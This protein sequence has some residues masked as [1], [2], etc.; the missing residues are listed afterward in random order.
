M[1]KELRSLSQQHEHINAKPTTQK[2]SGA[3]VVGEFF[4]RYTL[5]TINYIIL[6]LLAICILLPLLWILMTSLKTNVEI[7]AG[8]FVFPK[9]LQWGNYARAWAFTNMTRLFINT[10]IVAGGSM[11]ILVVLAVPLAY[12]LSRFKFKFSKVIAVIFMLGLFVNINYLAMPLYL[13]MFKVSKALG[14]RNLLVNN[15]IIVMVIYGVANLPFA[16]YLLG[17]Y[18]MGLS[19]GFE[20][21]AKIDGCGYLRTLISVVVPLAMPSIL[22]VI[23]FNFLTFW[24]EFIVANIFLP[25]EFATISIGILRVMR[26]EKTANDSSRMYAALIII[27]I[28]VLIGYAFVQNNLTKGITMGGMKG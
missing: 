4:R 28:P 16:S 15:P 11:V 18:F 26:I 27:I 5:K 13:M 19:R 21:A 25:D 22:T 8:A 3:E 9:R 7:E 1:N 6:F 24:N 14:M 20:E 12:V 2:R 17:G 10:I 23:L